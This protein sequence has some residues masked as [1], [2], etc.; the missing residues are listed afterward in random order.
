V[1]VCKN[2]WADTRDGVSG[3]YHAPTSR[4]GQ[5]SLIIIVT[6]VTNT[7]IP[8]LSPLVQGPMKN[9]TKASYDSPFAES[10]SDGASNKRTPKIDDAKVLLVA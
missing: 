9:L 3:R 10:E 1:F 7:T 4:I 6:I 2:G 5:T 8:P